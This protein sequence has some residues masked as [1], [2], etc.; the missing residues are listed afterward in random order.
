MTIDE[1]KIYLMGSVRTEKHNDQ[2][3]M[4]YTWMRGD[5]E[6]ATGVF[7]P[8]VGSIGSYIAHV[9]VMLPAED[10]PDI[11]GA[12]MLP[13]HIFKD[14]DALVLGQCGINLS[15]LKAGES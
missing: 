7:S 9:T 11:P 10:D 15:D 13:R 3:Y 6:I 4:D 14:E 12:T 1:A 2:G 5:A 8:Y